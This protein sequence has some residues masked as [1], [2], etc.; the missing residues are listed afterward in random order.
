MSRRKAPRGDPQWCQRLV[1]SRSP[2]GARGYSLD[3]ICRTAGV[4]SESLWVVAREREPAFETD[5]RASISFE[6]AGFDSQAQFW[7]LL[8]TLQECDRCHHEVVRGAQKIR[9]D[10]DLDWSKMTASFAALPLENPDAFMDRVFQEVLD[11]LVSSLERCLSCLGHAMD[12]ER[13]LLLCLSHGPEK[14]SAHLIAR[15]YAVNSAAEAAEIF[16]RVAAGVP[17][18]CRGALDA[19]VYSE[20]HPFRTLF[21]HKRSD[22]RRVKLVAPTWILRGRGV[23]SWRDLRAE[24]DYHADFLAFLDAAVCRTDGCVFVSVVGLPRPGS[25]AEV[26]GGV[27]LDE[28]DAGMLSA[29]LRR[30]CQPTDATFSIRSVNRSGLV[31][32]DARR[33][34]WCPACCR[35]HEHDNPWIR[36][37]TAGDSFAYHC[38]RRG[39]DPKPPLFSLPST[40]TLNHANERRRSSKHAIEDDDAA[41]G[42]APPDVGEGILGHEGPPGDRVDDGDGAEALPEIADPTYLVARCMDR[43]PMEALLRERLRSFVGPEGK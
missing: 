40:L 10:V 16:R 39:Y 15:G 24:S 13:D 23:V 6:Y 31:I 34:Y 27:V 17:E 22:P 14:R 37:S 20:G 18:A 7:A 33:P 43:H 3:E 32:L 21:S 25:C 30:A 41:D 26:A 12:V 1:E 42:T 2:D 29:M 38:H 11:E 9:F 35:V 4:P 19:G 8:R 36:V 28:E 5:G